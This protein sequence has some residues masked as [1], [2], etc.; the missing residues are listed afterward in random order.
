MMIA[1]LLVAAGSPI[2]RIG[3]DTSSPSHVNRIGTLESSPILSTMILNAI[4]TPRRSGTGIHSAARGVPA[5]LNRQTDSCVSV[6]G[7][8]CCT[9][10]AKPLKSARGFKQSPSTVGTLATAMRDLTQQIG[11]LSQHFAQPAEIGALTHRLR[12]GIDFRNGS[13]RVGCDFSRSPRI[14]RRLEPAAHSGLHGC[15]SESLV[16]LA[17]GQGIRR[18]VHVLPY[19]NDLHAGAAAAPASARRRAAD[20]V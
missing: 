11:A 18:S 10:W 3:G 9:D 5:A 16:R 12:M 8:P 7:E 1:K 19:R 17:R 13:S 15:A 2:Q 20:R 6:T 14:F 4:L